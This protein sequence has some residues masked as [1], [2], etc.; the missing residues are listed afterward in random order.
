[1][2]IISSSILAIAFC[3]AGLVSAHAD[4]TPPPPRKSIKS[5]TPTELMSLRRGVAKMMARNGAPRGS[6]DWR[7]SWV[8]WAN[9]H[10]HFGDDCGGPISGQGMAGVQAFTATDAA[11]T[12]T[13]CMCE[14]GT[15]QFLTWHRMYLWYF[16][17][18]LQEAAGDTSLRLPYWDYESDASL[19]QAYRDATYVNE[20]GATVPNPLRVAA[21][22][23]GL[24]N[25]TSSLAAAVVSTSNAMRNASFDDFGGALEDTPHGAVHCAIVTRGC[26]NGLMGS[27]P[28]S[29]L[30]PI[31][32]AHH[33]NIDRL[34]D[35][36]LQVDPNGRLPNDAGQRDAAFSFVDGD[37]SVVTRRVGDMLTAA[38]LGYS[39]ASGGGCP[40]AAQPIAAAAAG[41]AQSIEGSVQTLASAGPTRLSGVKTNVPLTVS[42]RQSLAP[43]HGAAAPTTRVDAVIDGLRY[44]KAPG[45]LFNVYLQGPGNARVL[46]GVINFFGVAPAGEA[47]HAKARHAMSRKSVR[48]DVTDALRQ[49]NLSADK[50]PSLVFEATTGLTGSTPEGVAAALNPQANV[51]FDSA[52]LVGRP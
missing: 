23:P 18:V 15:N 48:F 21:R 47:E 5:L 46:I 50:A 32:Y 26:P 9:M 24:N 4:E 7:R 51:Q 1:M 40:P 30:D 25:G 8:Y 6:A 16:E 36:W 22:Q 35:C 33:T 20:T 39:Y 12:A 31:F 44:E 3:F 38:G 43:P 2:R 52:R 28:V 34:Y 17:R 41:H 13:W 37:G 45:A 49:L 29:A 14:H 11:E 27:I 10:Q 19:P 42:G